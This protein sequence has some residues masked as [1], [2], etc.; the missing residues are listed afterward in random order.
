MSKKNATYVSSALLALVG[1]SGLLFEIFTV[2]GVGIKLSSISDLINATNQDL[3]LEIVIAYAAFIITL[4]Y[5]AVLAYFE[6][7]P[8]TCT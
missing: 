1:L 4:F 8:K 7:I 5:G 2:F 3:P 6:L